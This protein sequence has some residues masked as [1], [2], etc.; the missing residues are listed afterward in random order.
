MLLSCTHV[1]RVP[2]SFLKSIVAGWSR[3]S[4]LSTWS[5]LW[6]DLGSFPPT[7]RSKIAPSAD[8]QA[9]RSGRATE[10]R[11]RREALIADRSR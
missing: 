6:P 10:S 11:H 4:P 8:R 9:L 7:F 5:Q 2:H 3:F 1:I